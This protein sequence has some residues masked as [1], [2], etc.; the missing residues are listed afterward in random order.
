MTNNLKRFYE[1]FEKND[2]ERYRGIDE[3]YFANLNELDKQEAWSFLEKSRKLSEDS[4]RALHI[5]DKVHAVDIFKKVISQ[6]LVKSQYPTQ[7]FEAERCRLLMLSY[8]LEVCAKRQY[9]LEATVF[10]NSEFEEVRAGFA[11]SVPYSKTIPE[12]VE[13]LKKMIL[14]ETARAP[15]GGAVAK[16]MAIHGMDFDVD[17]PKYKSTYLELRS[18]SVEDK[19]RAMKRLAAV[20]SPEYV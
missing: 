12:V 19:I 4:I 5:L 11:E 16:L 15:L 13:A 1:F 17:N 8:I 10:S 3:S 14:V 6:P 9:F 18:G 7:R 2:S 20:H